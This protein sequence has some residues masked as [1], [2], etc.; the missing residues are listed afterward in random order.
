MRRARS[1]LPRMTPTFNAPL[2]L[3]PAIIAFLLAQIPVL[4]LLVRPW[5]AEKEGWTPA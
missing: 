2:W 3:L 5:L 4:I 1:T